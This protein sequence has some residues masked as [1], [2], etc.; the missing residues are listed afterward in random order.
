MTQRILILGAGFAGVS[1]ARA[2]ERALAPDE[3]ELTIVG[4]DNFSLFTPMLPEVSAGG[5]ETRH[6]VTPVRA[7]LRRA[8][9]VLGDVVA[10]DLDAR[11]V[12]VQH[13]IT[14]AKQTLAYDQLVLALGSVTSTFGIPGVA[15]HALPLKTLEDAERLRNRAIASL[16]LADVTSDPAERARLLTYV[17]VGGGYTGVEAAGEWI[18]LFRS[19]TPFYASI[20]PRDVRMVLIEAGPTL[21]AGLPP[22]MSRYAL[23]NL[24]S[25][26]V[27][28]HVG[29]AVT[30]VDD[31]T[32]QLAG[33]VAIPTATV[34]WSAGVRPT[35]VLRDLPLQH[36]RNGGIIVNRDFSV[37]ERPGVWALG[38]CAWIPTKTAGEWYPMTA[39]HAIREGPALAKNIAALQRGRQTK[40]FDFTALGTMASLGARRGVASVAGG[41]VITGFPAWFLWRTYYLLRLPGLD[42]KVRV[43]LDWLLGLIFRRDIAEL[44]LYTTSAGEHASGDAG[45]S[46]RLDEMR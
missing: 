3:A 37:P 34:L 6:I 40:P 35:P 17:I 8:R 12:D 43:A 10:I 32:I 30:S 14:G 38:D 36:A 27:E 18:D 9:F 28:V 5:L 26:G 45:L 4:R 29:D 44:R 23:K 31:R 20:S 1:A 15:E 13:S 19:I 42:R 11:S 41:L 46:A 22:A 24:T 2:L 7:E 33:G 39:Q 25:R 16:E 21:L